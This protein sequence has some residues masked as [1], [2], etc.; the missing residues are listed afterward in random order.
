MITSRDSKYTRIKL[1]KR[2]ILAPARRLTKLMHKEVRTEYTN[3][4][5]RCD[6]EKGRQKILLH[7]NRFKFKCVSSTGPEVA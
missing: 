7:C 3:Q 5:L 4:K 6:R 2:I 1:L